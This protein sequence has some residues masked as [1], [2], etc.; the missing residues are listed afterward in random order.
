MNAD[1]HIHK[2][3]GPVFVWPL[4]PLRSSGSFLVLFGRANKLDFRVILMEVGEVQENNDWI[5]ND[6]FGS[7]VLCL[8]GNPVG[9]CITVF[10]LSVGQGVGLWLQLSCKSQDA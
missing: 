9:I 7:S 1:T 6:I 4:S 3:L 8:C 5:T 10:S 2:I